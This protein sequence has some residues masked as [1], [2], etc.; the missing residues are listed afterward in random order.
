MNFII[1][2]LALSLPLL[3]LSQTDNTLMKEQEVIEMRV[4]RNYHSKYK[5]QLDLLQKTYP[6]ALK[7]KQ[8]IDEYEKDVALL[9]KKRLQKKYSKQMHKKLKED[10]TYSIRDLYRSEGRMLMKLVHRETGMTVNEI[11]KN[12]RNGFQTKLYEG[13]ASIFG[14]NLDATYDAEGSDWITEAVISD[15]HSRRVEFNKKMNTVNKQTYKDGMKSYR[16]ERKVSRKNARK[17]K[18]AKR[19]ARDLKSQASK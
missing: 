17:N 7:A 10:F 15:I 13:L 2:I 5:R 11:L 9:D 1:L 16:Y 14:Q 6:M 3:S 4:D 8:L 19:K 18:R 12:Y